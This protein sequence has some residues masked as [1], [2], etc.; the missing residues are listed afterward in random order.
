MEAGQRGR[1][2]GHGFQQ[3]VPARHPKMPMKPCHT[4]VIINQD[5]DQSS[6]FTKDARENTKDATFI[7]KT[8]SQLINSKPELQSLMPV[9]ASWNWHS[10]VRRN[11]FSRE[12]LPHLTV[13]FISVLGHSHHWFWSYS[14]LQL[15]WLQLFRPF[16][17]YIFT[18]GVIFLFKAIVGRFPFSL[19][20]TI[21]TNE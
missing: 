4:L 15:K 12:Q 21:L 2:L 1:W 14:W 10:Q 13:F 11:F 8:L 3:Q 18:Q 17:N 16:R 5:P 6:H 9:E 19:F 20:L 7:W